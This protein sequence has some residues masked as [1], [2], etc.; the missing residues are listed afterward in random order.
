MIEDEVL[1][2]LKTSENDQNIAITRGFNMAFGNLSKT[3]LMSLKKE[4]VDTLITNAVPK[5]TEA[6]DAETRKQAVKSLIEVV[7]T[8]G[9]KNIAAEQRT[10]I[11]ETLY[12]GFDDYAIDKRGDVGSWVRQESMI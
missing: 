3:L 4:V 5:N 2:M 9:I 10:K 8:I 7:K 12:R 1:K 11:L 6:D